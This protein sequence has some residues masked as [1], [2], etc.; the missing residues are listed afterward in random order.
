MNLK[1]FE[2]V[3][4]IA[5]M[6]SINKAANKLL[7][8]Q[9]YLSSCLKALEK[10][11]GFSI[12]SRTNNGVIP[13]EKGTL[14]LQYAGEILTKMNDIRLLSLENSEKPLNF[15]ALSA[16]YIMK[17]FLDFKAETPQ[18]SEDTLAEYLSYASLCE[19]ISKGKHDIG[20]TFIFKSLKDKSFNS[21]ENNH[22]L[23]TRCILDPVSFFVAMHKSHPLHK[24][25]ELSPEELSLY[26]MVKYQG[27]T[28][29]L[30]SYLN[31]FN[32]TDMPE[33]SLLV[34]NR[35]QLFDALLS[36]NYYAIMPCF[37]HYANP[38]LCYIPLWD[39][40]FS[41]S[42]NYI[43]HKDHKFSSREKLFLKYIADHL[44]SS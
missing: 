22:N 43:Y 25:T 7:L 37:Q 1:Y 18:K 23:R 19:A 32:L 14:F 42:L 34:S 44:V 17:L 33:D 21:L 2:Y 39:T 16:S 5:E 11:I 13:T 12:F 4:C 24:R 30:Q 35:G 3:L 15:A 20:I 28:A 8:S 40:S 31:I 29:P 9:S 41:V 38:D 27:T 26:P 6:Q 10:E 36:G